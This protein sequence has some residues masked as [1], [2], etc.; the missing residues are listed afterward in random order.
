MN[1]EQQRKKKWTP[2]NGVSYYIALLCLLGGRLQGQTEIITPDPVV[3]PPAGQSNYVLSS[4][5]LLVRSGQSITLKPGVH[6]MA[7]STVVLQVDQNFKIPI[8]PDNPQAN[9][10]M[11]WILSRN[12]SASGQVV[13]ESKVFYD[14]LGKASQQQTK[15]LE[16]G[17]VMASQPLY[18]VFGEAVGS[19]LS[20]P[21][22]NASFAYKSDFFTTSA[23]TTYSFRNFAR[24]LN[25][26]GTRQDKTA[27]ADAVG[28]TVAGT[29]GWYYSE[30]NSWEPYQD[31]AILP[32]TVG[33]NASN[34][35]GIF[36]RT[37]SVGNELR[38]GKNRE[39]VSFSVP[40]TKELELY[41][42]IRNKYFTEAEVGGRTVVD[43]A[44][45]VMSVSLDADRNVGISIS[46]DGKSVLSA[47]GGTEL[48]VAKTVSVVANSNAYFPVF[49]SQSVSFS[50]AASTLVNYVANESVS[51]V[52]TGAVTLNKGL[53][54]LRTATG[55]QT[56]SYS[57]GL[58]TISMNF[59]DQLGRLRASIPP[60]GIK[61]LLNG[62]LESYATLA[63]I[64][65][66]QTFEYNAQGL[67]VTSTSPDKG[68][69]EM[70]Y[71]TEGRIR[72]SQNTLQRQ[73]GSYS[74]TNYD[75]YGRAIQ[76]GEYLPTGVGIKFENIT[77]T[78]LDA[79]GLPSTVGTQSDV[80]EIQYDMANATHGVAGY[81]QDSYFLGGAV[82]YTA[83]YSLLSNNVK[84]AAKLVSRT[85]FSYNGDG[86]VSWTINNVN[87]L[88]NKTMDYEY[89][90]F[91]R[92]T[93]SVY[94]K[95]I[96]S[97][98]FVH[99]YEYDL[100]GNLKTVYTNTVDQLAS[101]VLH[102][103]Y[104]YTL[105][106]ALKRV[107]Y[108][109]KLQGV[110]YVYTIDGKLKS[111]N[112]ANVGANGVNDPGKD[113]KGNGFAADVFSQ[114]MEYYANDYLRAGT[115]IYGIQNASAPAKYSGLVNGIGWQTQK[116]NSVTGLDATT[117]NIFTYDNKGQ[118]LANIWGTPDYG[119]KVFTGMANV[120]QEKGI[121]YDNHGN[122]LKLQRTNSAGAQVNNFT[123]NYQ[124][125]TNKLS[126]VTG[127][128]TYTY[129]AIG[130]LTS[131]VKGAQGMYLDYDVA[132][133][134]TAI[135][136]DNA[137]SV[138]MLSFVYDDGGNRVMKKDH[139]TNVV[140]WYSYDAAGS[141]MAVFESKN[142]G[143]L[144]LTEQP[145]Y[146]SSRLGILNR[147]GASY[148]YTLVDHLGNTRA[149]IN[150][151][152]L[153]GGLAD[154]QYYA[155][156]YP[157][158]TEARSA[159][160]DSRYGYQGL[161][162]EKDK[163]T[164]WNSFELRNYDATIGRWLTVD[165]MGQ[166]VSPYVGMGNNPINM[167]D[168]TGGWS[169][170]GWWDWLKG[171][172]KTEDIK[173]VRL[174]EA[175]VYAFYNK[176]QI[177]EYKPNFWERWRRS[178]N[179]FAKI[180]Y[181]MLDAPYVYATGF[182][183]FGRN[184]R[185]LGGAGADPKEYHN[186]GVTTIGMALGPITTEAKA[187]TSVTQVS[188]VEEGLY[189]VAK[190]DG[191]FYSVAFE[192]ELAPTSYPGVSRYK[193]F[194]EANIA[195][196][197]AMETNPMLQQMGISVPK[198]SAGSIMGTSPTNWVWHHHVNKGVMQ[199]VPKSQHPNVPGGIFWNS[200]HPNGIGGWAIWGK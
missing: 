192:M 53:Y 127:Y 80:N 15:N 94:Q 142:G 11:N 35:S 132:G 71:N 32:Y 37:A 169:G 85:W 140:T 144:Q 133:K 175:Q 28:G 93:K 120:N 91:G 64:P 36:S 6:F 179:F 68:R 189:Q 138:I 52:S 40:I 191:S 19:T 148:S 199:L 31:V 164:G 98:T 69:S 172:F 82:S 22:N 23:G 45:R 84:D 165:P 135:Y 121:S 119:T 174:E 162:A 17:H 200:M 126:S 65:F 181:D 12:F 188:L 34:G 136:S 72:F 88:G 7:G 14:D 102:A 62:G 170:G 61:K 150:R 117:M 96:T 131:Q 75:N 89:D 115:N 20:A 105:T 178:S 166:Y 101:K 83:K 173:H 33:T 81:V 114:N 195:L 106:G 24:Y 194:Q 26:A 79:A 104:I 151:T 130:Q 5:S 163:E 183:S 87:G 196:E 30:A 4:G 158:G 159:G 176:A 92:V 185:H 100:N 99:Y 10:D 190:P 125:G 111:I 21:I 78:M 59:Y 2:I 67:L 86:N 58:G 177:K 54:E 167:F 180:P 154:V 70:K 129:D 73:K 95:N 141:L 157:F 198:S 49:A 43:S 193:H 90:E 128:A 27:T 56:V 187:M 171:I 145:V 161:Y 8:A 18:S 108:G 77:T 3:L 47:L 137:K 74:Y 109:D 9:T 55:A 57:L 66:V 97:E 118:F 48:T 156:Y 60:E 155:D 38:M 116:P 113:G 110:D 46:V 153:A 146:G 39:A 186:A 134:V 149:V 41:E 13:S 184:A 51:N 63:G 160:I 147:S 50:G 76:S 143:A 42:S 16:Y 197:A 29:L 182:T 152:K 112:N 103:K 123:Y 107:E 168:P 1:I 139:R 44:A 122:L 25:A 124:I